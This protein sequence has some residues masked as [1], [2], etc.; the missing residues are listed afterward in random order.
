MSET[1]LAATL[2]NETTPKVLGS[3][4]EFQGGGVLKNTDSVTITFPQPFKHA[5]VVLLTSYWAGQ[6]SEVGHIETISHVDRTGFTF[7][8]SNKAPNYYVMWLAVANS[9]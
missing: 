3:A 7:I 1:I 6:G 5:P 4:L 9:S 2:G 8:S